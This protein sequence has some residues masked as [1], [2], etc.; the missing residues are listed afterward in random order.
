MKAFFFW[1]YGTTFLLFFSPSRIDAQELTPDSLRKILPGLSDT[2]RVDCLNRISHSYHHFLE[3]IPWSKQT[4]SASKYAL[5]AMEDAKGL[6]YQRGVAM[7]NQNLGELL[8]ERGAFNQAEPFLFSAVELYDLLKLSP[9][10]NWNR[11]TLGWCLF[12]QGKFDEGRSYIETAIPYY[13]SVSDTMLESRAYRMIGNTYAAQGYFLKAFE[14]A[15][16]AYSVGIKRGDVF[17]N[18]NTPEL[19]G[20]LFLILEDTIKALSLFREGAEYARSSGLES[21]FLLKMADICFIEK[22]YDSSFWFRERYAELVKLKCLDPAIVKTNLMRNDARLSQQYLRMGKY[23]DAIR[24]AREPLLF[25]KEND[26]FDFLTVLVTLAS[27]YDG[28]LDNEHVMR[29]AREILDVAGRTGRRQF[30]RD[31]Y[32]LLWRAYEREKNIN[33]AHRYHLKYAELKDVIDGDQH[34]QKIAASEWIER[35]RQ[36]E[37]EIDLLNKENELKQEQLSKEQL[38]KRILIGS[39]LIL[40][41]M[42]VIGYRNLSLRKRNEKL[43]SEKKQAALQQQATELEM[44]ALRAQMNPHFIFNSLNSISHFILHHDHHQAADYLAK[45]SKLIRLILQNSVHPF[46]S[47][48]QE[49]ESLNLFL[50]LEAVR[51]G[52][53]FNYRLSVEDGVDKSF[54]KVPPSI[55]QPYVENSVWHGLMHKEE[56]GTIAIEVFFEGPTLYYK[57]TDDGIGR[58]GSQSFK[59][60]SSTHQSMGTR[61][62]E[63]RIN[64]LH[65]RNQPGSNVTVKDL[66]NGDGTPAGTEVLLNVPYR[67]D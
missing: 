61:L 56:G 9:E 57:I 20:N 26:H 41:L 17:G 34:K 23:D 18:L 36:L 30:M 22:S 60:S 39:F 2:A 12:S 37:A 67:H 15:Q 11:L 21:A 51:F 58:G 53:R 27:A 32:W 6:A 24:L 10:L 5:Q 31:G 55:L 14:Y 46:I 62:T 50:E 48:E 54:V 29:Y 25:Y 66:V 38:L 8:C 65:Y 33:L 42:S 52:Q 63:H 3:P 59:D 43:L 64:L 47:L 40:V 45:F 16:K 7:A 19:K 13:Q 44:Q 28:K 1:L 4:D 49:L 35:D